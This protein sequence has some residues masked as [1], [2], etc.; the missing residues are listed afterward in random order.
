MMATDVDWVCLT[1]SEFNE[2]DMEPGTRFA[3][4]L[5]D[6]QSIRS[7]PDG[8]II[9]YTDGFD[10]LWLH[11]DQPFGDLMGILMGLGNFA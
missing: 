9:Y 10:M 2:P 8:A 7:D 11:V 1:A 5:R 4:R 6:I 3:V